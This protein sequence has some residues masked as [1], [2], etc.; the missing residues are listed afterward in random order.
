MVTVLIADDCIP[1]REGIKFLI[2]RDQSIKVVGCANDG[3][4]A[5]ELNRECK[6]DIVLMNIKMPNYDGIKGLELIKTTSIKTKVIMLTTFYDAVNITKALKSGADGYILKDV[7][8]NELISSIKST[9]KG[10]RVVD[11]NI[12]ETIIKHFDQYNELE[13][14]TKFKKLMAMGMNETEIMIIK[15]IVQGKSNKEISLDIS[16]SEGRVKNIVSSILSRLELNDRTQLA[17]FAIQNK[18][19]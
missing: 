10:L 2:E 3:F 16:L 1:F 18:M 6:P 14:T 15:L 11:K 7:H 4:E 13:N 5:F 9:A 8:P 19:L 12:Y 17:V